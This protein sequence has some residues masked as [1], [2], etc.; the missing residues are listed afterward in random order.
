[1]TATAGPV[2]VVL[3]EQDAIDVDLSRWQ[4]LAARSL[5]T[6]GAVDG[7]LN[8]IFVGEA[9]MAELNARHMGKDYA[10]DVLAFP[11]DGLDQAPWGQSLI[12]DVVVC[13]ARA[14]AQA[15]DHEGQ[16]GHDGSLEDELALLIVHGVLHLL[17]YDH[18][19]T[20]TTTQ[21]KSCE[22]ALLSQHHRRA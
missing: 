21:M 18:H 15:A 6:S 17:G 11:L 10:T 5:E 19:D 9:E 7:E 20:S 2:V 3:N 14:A 4:R 12:G 16:A 13:P 22:Q 1:M 8:L